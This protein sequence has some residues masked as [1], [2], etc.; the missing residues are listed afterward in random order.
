MQVANNTMMRRYNFLVIFAISKCQKHYNSMSFYGIYKY[1]QTICWWHQML[2]LFQLLLSSYAN[3]V[4]YRGLE[5][6]K[7]VLSSCYQ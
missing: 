4:K 7:I 2:C 5:L 3:K 1:I 6:F